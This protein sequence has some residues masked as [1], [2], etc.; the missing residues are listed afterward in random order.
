MTTYIDVSSAVHQRA[1]M[2]RYAASL[3]RTLIT[4]GGSAH[5]WGLFYNSASPVTAPLGLL[6][7]PARSVRAGYKPWRMAVWLGHLLGIRFD[8]MLPDG[9]L[10]HATEHLLPNFRSI[11]TVLTVHDLI[12][13]LFPAYH[14]RLNYWY[15]NAAMP[16]FIRRADAVVTISQSSKRDLMR[17]YNVPENKITVIYEAASP[18]FGPCSTEQ[19]AHAKRRYSLPDRYLLALGTIEPR[20]NLL[21]LVQALQIL[22]R[23]DPT[24]CL[25]IVG[26]PG[27]MYQ[28]FFQHLEQLPDPKAVLLSGFV[29]DS[30]LPAVISGAQVYVLASVY[31]GFGLPILEAMACGTPVVCSKTSSMPE[32]GGSAASYFD[33]T[34]TGDMA[35]QIGQVLGSQPMRD[36]MRVRGI[37]QAALFSWERTADET[38]AVYD[39]VLAARNA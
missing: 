35:Y 7:T 5:R 16:V 8:S 31:E 3:A 27:W 6:G 36:S 30:D 19:V 15:L 33:P 10:F 22:R 21:R 1:G 18:H 4:R 29:P 38:L 11:P 37:A 32:L 2:A 34:N 14:R 20:K 9:E 17:V 26:R 23:Q 12:Y 39:R 25:V 24:L 13:N 28:D